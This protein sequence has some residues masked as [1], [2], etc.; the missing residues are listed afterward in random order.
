MLLSGCTFFHC[1]HTYSP[2][3]M[4]LLAVC[5]MWLS[6]AVH[7]PFS[8]GYHQLHPISADVMT[9][10]R[11]LDILFIYV[12]SCFLTFTFSHFALP[13]A[14]TLV[15]TGLCVLLTAKAARSASSLKTGEAGD[16]LANIKFVGM[17]VVLYYMPI[18][19]VGVQDLA[20]GRL[21]VAV[22]CAGLVP[23]C[24]LAGGV[25][26]ALHIPNK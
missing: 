14:L 18:A 23:L 6:I 11:A 2:Q 3:G 16:K 5:S 7:A 4:D 10:W 8:I 13:P 24:L 1:L 26:Y 15:C 17:A 19:V 9:R 12:A 20:V 21:T 22:E 25:V